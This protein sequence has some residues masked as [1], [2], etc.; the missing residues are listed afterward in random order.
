[1]HPVHSIC[2][3][4]LKLCLPGQDHVCDAKHR[5]ASHNPLLLTTNLSGP[6]FGDVLG[7][8]Q[9][10]AHAA[11]FLASPTPRDA[12]LTTL[13]KAALPPCVVATLG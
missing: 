7:A 5:V 13:A 8:L 11:G 12:F 9:A 2:R 3:H 6:L 4:S 10:L 1:M